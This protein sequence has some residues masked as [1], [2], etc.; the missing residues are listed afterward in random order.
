[1]LSVFVG[2]LYVA[3]CF[4][5]R[6]AKMMVPQV[7]VSGLCHRFTGGMC[8]LKRVAVDVVSVS[9]ASERE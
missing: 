2:R 8:A 4:F 9:A 7:G 1:M 6:L 3:V 5:I